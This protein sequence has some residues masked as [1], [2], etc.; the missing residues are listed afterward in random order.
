MTTL[1]QFLR[2]EPLTYAG[3]KPKRGRTKKVVATYRVGDGVYLENE[4]GEDLG[5]ADIT[6]DLGASRVYH[7]LTRRT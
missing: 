6:E 4:R 1:S 2:G 5:K 3:P 7:N